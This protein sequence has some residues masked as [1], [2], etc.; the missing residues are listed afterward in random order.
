MSAM[1]T[2][3]WYIATCVNGPVPVTSPTPHTPSPP[4]IPP[5][6]LQCDP[7]PAPHDPR[8]RSR[9]RLHRVAVG[10]VPD[11]R[12]TRDGRHRGR[13]PRGDHDPAPRGEGPLADTHPARSV[14]DA[15]AAH[16]AAAAL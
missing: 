16:E 15:A 2:C 5:P 3:A 13:R 9:L 10:P 6:H 8:R 7:T 4:P 14:E 11:V 1:A 12:E